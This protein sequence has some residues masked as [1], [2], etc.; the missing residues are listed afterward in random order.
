MAQSL[1]Q[2]GGNFGQAIGPLLAAFIVVP[3]GQ[4]SIVWFSAAALL[5]MAMLTRVGGWYARNQ[6]NAGPKR[7]AGAG[8][9]SLPRGKVLFAVAILVTLIFS[10]NVYTAS[11]NSYYTFYLI[12]TFGI[13]IQE[14]QLY[15]FIYLVSIV[16]GLV[17]GGM[18][19][20]RVGRLPVIWFSILGVLPFTLV[21]P[22]V[23][24]TATVILTVIIG[25]I[26]S[27][28]FPAILVYAQQLMP[29]RIGLVAGIFFGFSFGLGGLGA[30][31]LGELADHVGIRSVYIAC[32]Y[33]PVLG[34]LTALLPNIEKRAA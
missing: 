25:L 23:G 11:L 30:A 18:V 31:V 4:H 34:I 14:A 16:V 32:A 27:S 22:Y 10:K 8:A 13:S 5:A 9:V 2:V 21:L 19:S 6:R 12:E 24:L 28:A 3:H 1:F 20:D 17:L 26:M 29:G 15:L 7:S 33:L